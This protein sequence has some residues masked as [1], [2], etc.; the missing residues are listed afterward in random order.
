MIR[1]DYYWGLYPK[2][3]GDKLVSRKTE[4]LIYE[5]N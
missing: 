4:S 1:F 5:E 2:F 3:E